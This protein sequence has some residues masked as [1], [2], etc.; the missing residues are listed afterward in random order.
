VYAS[1]TGEKRRRNKGAQDYNVTRLGRFPESRAAIATPGRDCQKENIAR[2][3]KKYDGQAV[4]DVNQP[5]AGCAA[6][7]L[8]VTLSRVANYFTK[9]AIMK[10]DLVHTNCDGTAHELFHTT[11]L[12]MSTS[13][14]P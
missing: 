2:E 5:M 14:C 12:Q 6:D 7:S 9:K 10:L 13:P 3:Q 11:K 8:H 4:V 1:C